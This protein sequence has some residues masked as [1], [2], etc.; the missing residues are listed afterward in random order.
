MRRSLFLGCLAASG[1]LA[2]PAASQPLA[3]VGARVQ[4]APDSQPILTGTVIVADGRIRA[5]GAAD[6]V[7]I[8][9]GA[10]EIDGRGLIALAGFQNSHVHFTEEHWADAASKPADVLEQQLERMLTSYGFTTVVDTASFPE[11]TTSLRRRIESGE[12]A[13]PRILT[14]GLALYPP[15]GVPFYVREAMPEE[16]LALLPQP[17]TAE[18]AREVVRDNREKGADVVKLFTGSWVERGKVLPMT[19]EVARGAADEAR[20]KGMVVFSHPSN[21]AGLEVA[22]EAGVDVLAHA[23]DD[24][25]GFTPE[26]QARLLRQNVAIVPTLMLFGESR[27]LWEIGDFV[28]DHAREG[29]QI[30]FGTDVGYLTE[31][32]P[33]REYELLA[34]MGMSWR[35]IVASL[36]TAPAAR[37]G[38]SDRRGRIAPGMDADIVLIGSDPAAGVAA[39]ADVRYTVRGG[40]VIYRKDAHR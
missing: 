21:V 26:H 29:G 35:E 20:A 31:Y 3:I 6:T 34:A 33:R 28:R 38:E 24:T 13:G 32:D 17:G 30:L 23:V 27:F 36:T 22:L 8:P 19:E 14:A 1:A 9:S 7:S 18:A 25:R 40:K 5:V 10:V 16:V 37:F 15:D 11:N 4:T 2:V 39:F 12:I